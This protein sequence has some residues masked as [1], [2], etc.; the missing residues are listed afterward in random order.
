[1]RSLLVLVFLALVV[2]VS[3]AST[4]S[5]PTTDATFAARVLKVAVA[6]RAT[7]EVIAAL[8][9]GGFTCLEHDNRL[10]ESSERSVRYQKHVCGGPVPALHGC[11]R[12]VELGSFDG[13]LKHIRLSFEHPDGTPN[14]G[15]A[16][17]R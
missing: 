17:A 12:N 1:M 4:S 9:A 15:V 3:S 11:A 14:E 6:G 2:G 10:L 13:T 8:S 16:C 5:I 7:P